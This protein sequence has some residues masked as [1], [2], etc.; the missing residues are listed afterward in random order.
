LDALLARG[1]AAARVAYGANAG[2]D[3]FRGLY[4]S[5]EQTEQYLDGLAGRPLA[6][7]RAPVHPGWTTIAR[8][9][10]GWAWLCATYQLTELELDAVLLALGP[11]VDRRYERLYGYLQDDVSRRRPTVDLALDLLTTSAV[12]RL[13]ARGAFAPGAP[14]L[15]HRVLRLVPDSRTPEPPLLAHLLVPDEQIVDVLLGGAAGLDHRLAGYCRLTAPEPDDAV[16]TVLRPDARRALLRAVAETRRPLR[17]YLQGPPGSGQQDV[18]RMLA[19]SVGAPLLE[20]DLAALPT[21]GTAADVV[22]LAVRAAALRGALLFVGDV[23]VVRTAEHRATREALSTHLA[24]HPGVTL[25]SGAQPWAALGRDPLG[26]LEVPCAPTDAEARRGVWVRTLARH[27]V[28]VPDGVLDALADRFR[29]GPGQIAD[30]VQTALAATLW[31]AA[32]DG[33]IGEEL[34]AAA[35]RQTGEALAALARRVE[36]VHGW[37]DLVLPADSTE[38]LHEICDRV[39]YRR[40]VLDDWGF[41]RAL[42]QG[43][44]VSALF[45]GPPGTGKTM[46]A[47]VIARELGLDLFTIDLSGVVD[48]YIGETEKNL[49]R[50]FTA[51]TDANAILFFDEADALF[52]KR[53]QVRDAHDRY[54]N[55]EI[56]YL[57]QRMEQY[58]G[59]TILATNLRQH[60]DDAF[61][62][63]LAFVVEFPFPDDAQRQRIWEV[64]LPAEL[65]RDPEIDLG[66]LAREFRLAGGNIRNVVLGAAFLAAADAA[67]VGMGHLLAANRREHQKMG[68]VL[69]E[70]RG[71]VGA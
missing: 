41:D 24:R 23:P 51:A 22:A 67:P 43:K 9:D 56:A 66:W 65:P 44:G 29:L 63:R 25:L 42:S 48:K 31:Q 35:R 64:C 70:P 34:F 19:A 10:P 18:A 21:D 4:V 58:E 40:R 15:A 38:A 57:L 53:S 39:A 16:E 62:R 3:S 7:G 8:D 13:A 5:A 50:L 47:E 54:A 20:L 52:G 11:E 59:L 49:E 33:P 32:T 2:T 69:A 55:I 1:V 17:L 61:T 60:L 12:Q 68:R 45:V 26:V 37:A 28:T 36:P 46:A 6:D 30:A 14:L 27:G 71:E